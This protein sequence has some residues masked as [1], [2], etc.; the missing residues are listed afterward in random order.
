ME[1]LVQPDHSGSKH[2]K[3]LEISRIAFDGT[4]I[5]DRDPDDEE[6]LRQTTQTHLKLILELLEPGRLK[7][8][9][10]FGNREYALGV[11]TIEFFLQ[12]QYNLQRL[13]ISEDLLQC[14]PRLLIDSLPNLHTLDVD[15]LV[16]LPQLEAFYNMLLKKQDTIKQIAFGFVERCDIVI[17]LLDWT[18]TE[19]V[20]LSPDYKWKEGGLPN[21]SVELR[22]L[23][24]LS[25]DGLPHIDV[26]RKYSIPGF[27]VNLSALKTLRLYE[28]DSADVFLRSIAGCVPNLEVLELFRSSS[29]Q[30]FNTFINQQASLKV[31]LLFFD[32]NGSD[33]DFEALHRLEHCLESFWLEHEVKSHH[34]GYMSSDLI[35]FDQEMTTGLSL[36]RFSKL[37][38]LA[39]NVDDLDTLVCTQ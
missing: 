25:I 1:C 20:L 38:E 18:L 27:F 3:N 21:T 10:I 32:K 11:E 30:A 37:T 19:N 13:W 33:I 8:L 22:A 15:S 39:L 29:I 36:S 17:P 9:M 28:C 26:F 7:S 6:A 16:S 4:D 23:Q 34:N 5:E 12:T 35:W 31:L 2:I 14:N 24:H